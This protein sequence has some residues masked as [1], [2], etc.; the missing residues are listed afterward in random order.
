MRGR[1]AAVMEVSEPEKKAESTRRPAI[2]SN[3]SIS[4]VSMLIRS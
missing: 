4:P 1:E 2:E 3:E